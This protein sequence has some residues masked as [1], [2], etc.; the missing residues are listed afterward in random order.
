MS[1]SCNEI[2]ASY[3]ENHSWGDPFV[4]KKK[5][6][7]YT[8]SS[9][10][11]ISLGNLTILSFQ[12]KHILS[13]TRIVQDSRVFMEFVFPFLLMK[14]IWKY[15]MYMSLQPNSLNISWPG[16]AKYYS[17]SGARIRMLGKNPAIAHKLYGFLLLYF[18][19]LKLPR[20][21]Q[22]Y[23][24]HIDSMYQFTQGMSQSCNEM[25]ASYMENTLGRTSLVGGPL[26]GE[27]K[28]TFLYRK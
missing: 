22:K 18:P 15:S 21:L 4:A 5:A 26:C 20:R 27:K 9:K 1:Q 2:L 13:H 6:P 8:E 11:S 25:L 24:F 19:L 28:G 16:T 3:M 17:F 23:I 14:S 12:I 7:F 10:K